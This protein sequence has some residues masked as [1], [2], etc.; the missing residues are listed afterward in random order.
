MWLSKVDTGVVSRGMDYLRRKLVTP[1]DTGSD[2]EHLEFKVQGSELYTVTLDRADPGLSE[3]DCP[4]A[5]DA[6]VCK[7]VVA[8]WLSVYAPEVADLKK[9]TAKSPTRKSAAKSNA[10]GTKQAAERK[11]DL[12]FLQQQSLPALQ[13]WVAQTSQRDSAIAMQLRQWRMQTQDLPQTA[14][15]WR[16]FVTQAMPQRQGMYGRELQR[17]VDSATEALQPLQEQLPQQP[18]MVRDAT[19]KALLRLYKIWQTCDDSDGQVW[20]LYEWLLATI[21]SAVKADPPPASWLKVWIELLAADP[22]GNWNEEAF[23]AD[24]GPAMRSAYAQWA[25]KEWKLWC[26]AHPEKPLP[27]KQSASSHLDYPRSRHRNR[28]LWAMAQSQDIP[29]QVQCMRDCTVR[30]SDW[31]DLIDFCERNE[32]QRLAFAYAQEAIKAFPD[33]D[34]IKQ[35][36][37]KLYQR[38]GWDEQALELAQKLLD[39]SPADLRQ[40]QTLIDCAGKLGI[41]SDKA[42]EQQLQRLLKKHTRRQ[43]DGTDAVQIDI[44]LAWLLSRNDWQGALALYKRKDSLQPWPDTVHQ[45]AMALPASHAQESIDLLESILH[46]QLE[47]ATSPYRRELQLTR[48]ILQ[49]LPATERLFW[50]NALCARYYRKKRFVEGV[51]A[52]LA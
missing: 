9:P 8:A 17:W 38:D 32:Q 13:E 33:D 21:Q 11:A 20:E 7:H 40:L 25:I 52:L 27:H 46:R 41:A 6:N 50:R 45:L 48:S 16:S 34:H 47:H 5:S 37:L 35:R 10:G 36:M 24:A 31:A 15:Q 42:F 14:A 12:E 44:A 29:A 30:A 1:I 22:V 51:S 23:L 2:G 39:Q 43:K 49:R 3:C 18:A 4:H 19:A 28:F 26:K